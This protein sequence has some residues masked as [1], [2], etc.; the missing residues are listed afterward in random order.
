MLISGKNY[1]YHD[2]DERQSS[3]IIVTKLNW[4]ILEKKCCSGDR[5]YCILFIYVIV[6]E[7]WG[8]LY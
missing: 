8:L 6:C 7:C 5:M 1:Y 4:Y 3:D 2:M